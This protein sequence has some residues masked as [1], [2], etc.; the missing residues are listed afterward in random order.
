MNPIIV[1]I[2]PII[3]I[4]WYFVSFIKLLFDTNKIIYLSKI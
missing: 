4:K 2:I 1:I 3:M